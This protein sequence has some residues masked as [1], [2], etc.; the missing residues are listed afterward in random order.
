M[1]IFNPVGGG[2]GGGGGGSG[3]SQEDILRFL[4]SLMVTDDGAFMR[5]NDGGFIKAYAVDP[6]LPLGTETDLLGVLSNLVVDDNGS[7]MRS[8]DG[9]FVLI[10]EP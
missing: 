2:G 8:N 4:A 6:P 5:S 10:S 9:G 7:F 1:P 3:L